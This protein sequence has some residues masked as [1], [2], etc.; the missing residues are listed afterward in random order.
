MMR[1]FIGLPIGI[2]L[3]LMGLMGATA[4]ATAPA[5]TGVTNASA[6][7]L[8]GAVTIFGG[9]AGNDCQ[10]D[11]PGAICNSCT[12]ASLSAC[13][14]APLCPCNTARI[15]DNLVVT[16]TLQEDAG[17]TYNVLAQRAD[18]TSSYLTPV[19]SVNQGA[20]I[21]F[22]W[23]DICAAMGSTGGCDAFN[24]T[25][26]SLTVHLFIDKD[27]SGTFTTGEESTDVTFKVISP[28]ATTYAVEDPSNPKGVYSF[29]PYPGD[30][31]I[32]LED[33][34]TT[35]QF[36]LL[37]YNSTK[38]VKVRVFASDANMDG[39][40]ATSGLVKD[41]NIIDDGAAGASFDKN[42][43][44]GL[45]NGKLYFF[46]L[47][48]VDEAQ[49]V[50]LYYP[51]QASLPTVCTTAPDSSC[52]YSATPDQVLGLLSK[53]LNCFIATAAYGSMMEPKIDVFRA[54]RHKFLLRNKYGLSFVKW[55]Y[56]YG[57]YAARFIAD[58]PWLRFLARGLLW[59]LYGFSYMALR[60]G[61]GLAFATAMLALTSL[62]GLGWLALNRIRRRAT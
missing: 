17:S 3:G 44:D 56:D 30:E 36:P 53:D 40:I 38:A 2:L 60:F 24:A 46:R 58:K 23:T 1:A 39:A 20:F 29:T 25:T 42:I 43:V 52:A 18:S 61:F 47:A 5:V 21:D 19:T 26:N 28:D 49:N 50:V 8:V 6:S 27:G 57:P 14:T 33:V 31:K 9:V 45:E 7:N 10:A 54:F 12:T 35:S 22:R 34:N 13:A 59:P 41:L 37:S 55:Y 51:D 11:N 15:Y 48:V 62:I 32:Y 16:L 4:W